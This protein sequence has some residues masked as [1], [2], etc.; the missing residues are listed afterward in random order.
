MSRNPSEAQLKTKTPL[1]KEVSPP[2]LMSSASS[3]L[4]RWSGGTTIVFANILERRD[5][6]R[7]LR[8]INFTF[9]VNWIEGISIYDICDIYHAN[10]V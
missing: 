5:R 9:V 8:T 7:H 1:S 4:T 6:H 3:S 2:T 10:D